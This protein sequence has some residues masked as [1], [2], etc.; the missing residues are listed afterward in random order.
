[1]VSLT[2]HKTAGQNASLK[3][4]KKVITPLYQIPGKAGRI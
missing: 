4:S 1:M 2:N 3:S